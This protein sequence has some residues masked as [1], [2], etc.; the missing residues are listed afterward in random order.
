MYTPL[1]VYVVPCHK[2]ESQAVWVIFC[3]GWFK[4]GML[5][6]LSPFAYVIICTTKRHSRIAT[7]LP[8][9]FIK[10]VFVKA[11]GVV[12]FCVKKTPG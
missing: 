5:W 7:H 3:V 10:T 8:D 4:V 2:K 12:F 9:T 1:T 6:H 11:Q